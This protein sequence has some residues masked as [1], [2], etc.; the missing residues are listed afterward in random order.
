MGETIQPGDKRNDNPAFYNYN[1]KEMVGLFRSGPLR[2]YASKKYQIAQTKWEEGL[3][4]SLI[5]QKRTS[6]RFYGV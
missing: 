2:L 6:Y 5:I 3:Y 1:A 4:C